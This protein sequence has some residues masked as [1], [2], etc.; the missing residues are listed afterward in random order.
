MLSSLSKPVVIAHRGA[1]KLAPENTLAAF[2]LAIDQQADAIELD[3]QLSADKE[4][5]VF[6]DNKLDRTTN[7]EGYLRDHNYQSLSELKAGILFGSPY[8]TERIPTLSQVFTTFGKSIFYNIELKNLLTPFDSLPFLVNKLIKDYQL[9]THV[10]I[11]SFNPIALTKIERINPD[12]PKGILLKGSLPFMLQAAP[13]ST[14]HNYQSVHFSNNS[15]SPNFVQRIHTSGKLAFT[16][17]LNL[18]DEIL[19]SLR[20]GID[21]FF[22]DDPSLARKTIL[23]VDKN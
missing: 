13:F 18:P 8:H 4:V 23:S 9:E 7:G 11:S 22:T 14:L 12:L 3:V 2:R 10:L 17:T 16:Y 19:L 20:N 6:H 1:S 21:G 15:I 5:V